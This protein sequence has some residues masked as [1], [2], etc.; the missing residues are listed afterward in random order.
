MKGRPALTPGKP[1]LTTYRKLNN[2]QIEASCYLKLWSG[3]RVRVTARHKTKQ[4]ATQKLEQ[5]VQTRLAFNASPVTPLTPQ[6]SVTQLVDQYLEQHLKTKAAATAET[7]RHAVNKHIHPRIGQLQ[8]QEITT[9]VIAAF[10]TGIPATSA[11]HCKVILSGAVEQAIQYGVMDR[12][13]VTAAALPVAAKKQRVNLDAAAVDKFRHAIAA[14]GDKQLS[15]LVEIALATG[16]RIGELLALRVADVDLAAQP[17][18]VTV[19]GHVRRVTGRGLVRFDGAK[20][21]AGQRTIQINPAATAVLQEQLTRLEVDA[22][23]QTAADA[24]LFPSAAGSFL[25]PRNVSRRIQA[26][27]DG[28]EFAGVTLHSIRRLVA[29]S[30]ANSQA[31]SWG[32]AGVLGHS[33][34]GLTERVY[35]TKKAADASGLRL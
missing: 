34:S 16:M 13:P 20:T 18:T 21:A 31:G 2:G 30:L 19:S 17:A 1:G 26:A 28:T 32:A 23:Y 35:V 4:G 6:S 10:L 24:P 12:N 11:R 7:Y 5:R 3:K 25:D 9:P 14:T 8:L 22:V 33:D 29:T 15:A 27:L